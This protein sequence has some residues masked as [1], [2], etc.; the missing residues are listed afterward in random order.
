MDVNPYSSVTYYRIKA[1]EN[2]GSIS[3]SLIVKVQT[4][5]NRK[6]GMIVYPNP[7]V[8]KQFTVE[9]SSPAGMYK[10]K[11]IN[12]F[13]QEIM[14]TQWQHAGGSATKT[15]ELATSVGTGIYYLQLTGNNQNMQTKILVQ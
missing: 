13:G 7:V 9:L 6:D 3:Y 2:G 8:S 15:I 5:S 10:I 1:I 12:N 11:L 14:N 4:G